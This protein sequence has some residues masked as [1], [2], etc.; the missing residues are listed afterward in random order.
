MEEKEQKIE[1]NKENILEVSTSDKYK[2]VNEL[3][4]RSKPNSVYYTLLILSILIV[5]AGLLI[6]VAP[7]VIGGMLVTPLLTPILVISLGIAVGEIKSIKTATVLVLKSMVLTVGIS[8]LLTMAFGVNAIE[9]IIE[10][11]T[12]TALLYF[13]VAIASGAAATLAWVR[14][15]VADILPGVSIAVSIVPPLSYL[16]IELAMLN[17]EMSRFYALIFLFNLLGIILGSL[18]VFSLLKFHESGWAV[19]RKGEEIEHKQEEK[20]SEKAAKQTKEKMDEIKRNVEKI[21]ESEALAEKERPA[22]IPSVSTPPAV[23]STTTPT[24]APPV[25][26]PKE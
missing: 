10:N 19:K 16:G 2:T 9:S 22:D 15:E 5:S 25:E 24:T 3:F 12:R 6:N 11:S 4:E 20:K 17:F 13:I 8:A 21:A 23:I 26:P 1:T 14:K 18:I 7:I